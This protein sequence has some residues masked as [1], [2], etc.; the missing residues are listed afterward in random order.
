MNYPEKSP[1]PTSRVQK[2]DTLSSSRSG[3]LI[4]VALRDGFPWILE[5]VDQ[6]MAEHFTQDEQ[7]VLLEY[8]KSEVGQKSAA[9]TPALMQELGAWWGQLVKSESFWQ[10]VAELSAI[11]DSETAGSAQ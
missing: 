11:T 7:L 3:S 5:F 10:F 8:A 9:I 4:L 2:H 6:F 1:S